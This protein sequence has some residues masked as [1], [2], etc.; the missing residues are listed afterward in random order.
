MKKTVLT[1]LAVS[2]MMPAMAEHTEA[3]ADTSRVYD[4]DE[5]V[6]V[7]QSKEY[8]KLRQQPLSSTVLTT[9]EIGSLSVRDLREISDFVPSF[10]MPNY[11][12]R[13]TS[14]IYVRG[15][16]SRVNS[17][18]MGIYIDDIPL[19]NKSAF[20]SHTWQLD[21]VDILRG[22][23]G[24]LYGINT[25]GGLVRQYTKNPMRYQG[26]DINLGIGSR[27]YRNAEVAH[28]QKL[29]EKFAFS[30]AAFYDGTNGF[31]KNA[32]NGERADDMNEAGGRLRMV[33]QPTRKLSFD[34]MA[35]YQFVR[36]KAYPYGVLDP[37]SGDVLSDP[38][39]NHQSKYKRNMLNTGLAIKYQG[40]GFDFHSNTSYQ[41]LK[42]NLFMDNDYSDIDFV[43]VDQSQLSNALTQEFTVKSN[44]Q[45]RW[46]WTMGVF[47]SY[48]WLKTTAPNTFGTAFSSMMSQQIGGMIYQQMLKSMAARMGE[49]AAAAAIQRAGGVN[50]GMSL[51]VPCLFRTPQFNLGVFH[52]SNIDITDHLTATLGLRYDYTHAKLDYD[53]QGI[54]VLDFNIMGAA[55]KASLNTV[56]AHTEKANFNQLLP[57]IG[58]T[59]KFDNGS[60]IYALV[61]KGYRAGGF[62]VQMFGDIIQSDVQTSLQSVMQTAMQ[63]HQD[64]IISKNTH[65]DEVYASL[66]EGI[67]FKPEESWN[68]EVGTH[69]N[70]FDNLIHAD[71]SAFYMQIRNQQLSVFTEDYGYGRKMV[72]AGKSYS[73]GVEATLRGSALSNHLSWS[74]AYGYTH[75]AFKEYTTK[76][77]ARGEVV[78]YK[79]NKVPFV[80]AHTLSA[81]AD[82]RFD[83]SD[84]FVK[85]LTVGANFNAQGKTW[86]DEANTYS[87]KFY[88][89]LGAHVCADFG[90]FKLNVWGRNLTDTRYNT[91]A[92]S[93]KATGKEVFMAQRG[94]P[95][96]VGADLSIHF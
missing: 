14:S 42:D 24:T 3:I 48:T 70:L 82:Y 49:E 43:N 2:M 96:Q 73:C 74:V 37:V 10:V 78:D 94:N 32:L 80:P 84:Q 54:S 23:Q 75:A 19:M 61:T 27:F 59:Y 51:S 45:S 77:S 29:N 6:V 20:N 60:N 86:W 39:Q 21:R 69:L 65:S 40:L 72:N 92:F 88:G 15:I 28:Y 63:S 64:V 50:I 52:E 85:S 30:V 41:F 25:E 16:G 9:N 71:L 26:T 18:S 8:M 12:A 87:Q 89:V 17:P 33:F 1:A 31:W 90:V 4:L 38:N 81:M 95:F 76:A 57:K 11:G 55:A 44:N 66:L 7:S 83:F 47:G 35:D 34:W 91:F 5:V 58:L 36:Q 68:Y 46:H 56:F 62:N 22:P 79:D 13:F 93:S 53:T 67:K